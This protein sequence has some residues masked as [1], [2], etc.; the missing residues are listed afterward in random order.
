MGIFAVHSPVSNGRLRYN[1]GDVKYKDS[2]IIRMPIPHSE[3]S[4]DIVII[5]KSIKHLYLRVYPP[6]GRV[7]ASAPKNMSRARIE[8]SIRSRIEWIQK[9]QKRLQGR[10]MPAF[11]DRQRHYFN[12]KIYQ[13][14]VI[15]HPHPPQ[16]ILRDQTMELYIRKGADEAKK[17]NAIDEWYRQSM[18]ESIPPMI[19]YYERSMGVSVSSFGVKKMRTR[20][21][22]CNPSAGRIWLN[23][24]LAKYPLKCL[25]Y[26]VAHE[27]VHLLEPS[28][29]AR[30]Y[31]LMDQFVPKWRDY[32]RQLHECVLSS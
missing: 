28:H 8:R 20:W 1:D 21:G 19:V 16:L 17:C 13:L 10:G 3:M 23:L 7:Q 29:N 31:A 14:Q 24:E 22:T 30:F 27:M 25:D 11:S 32:R 4:C 2:E 15:E 6:D 9:Q 12:G 5:R 26:V 18:K